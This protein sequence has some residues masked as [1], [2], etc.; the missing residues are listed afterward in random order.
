MGLNFLG[1][2]LQREEGYQNSP[3]QFNIKINQHKHQQ[4]DVP[5]ASYIPAAPELWLPRTVPDFLSQ[6]SDRPSASQPASDSLPAQPESEGFQVLGFEGLTL[7]GFLFVLGPDSQDQR[8][9]VPD[10]WCLAHYFL[11][12]KRGCESF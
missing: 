3:K 7:L 8:F 5:D 10:A 12:A 6:A 2:I 4:R 1:S 9:F 11:A